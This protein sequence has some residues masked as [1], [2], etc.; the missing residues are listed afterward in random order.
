MKLFETTP[1]MYLL[2][3]SVAAEEGKIDLVEKLCECEVEC[4]NGGGK[5]SKEEFLVGN[6]NT[7]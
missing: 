6:E 3:H 5:M 1:C 7:N 2:V 4:G